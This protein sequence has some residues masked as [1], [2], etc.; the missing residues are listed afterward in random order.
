MVAERIAGEPAEVNYDLIPGVIYTHPEIAFVGRTVADCA[1]RS[2]EASQ[3]AFAFAANGRA[4][5]AG[6]S[7]GRVKLVGQPVSDRGGHAPLSAFRW[8]VHSAAEL[9]QQAVIAMGIRRR[10]RGFGADYISAHP[11]S[12][13]MSA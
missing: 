3:G 7:E 8:S 5:A 13:R 1:A 11:H 2:E 10:R 4:L 12:F 6:E 9:V